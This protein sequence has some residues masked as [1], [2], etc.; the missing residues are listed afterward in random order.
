MIKGL[1]ISNIDD[2]V[3][4]GYAPKIFGQV[5]AFISA[6]FVMT[7]LRFTNGHIAVR[8]GDGNTILKQPDKILNKIGSAI[9]KRI[10]LFA[11]SFQML[12]S[13]SFDFVY[14][15][16]TPF[17]PFLIIFLLLVR[18]KHR[19]ALNIIMEIPTYPYDKQYLS[20]GVISF[21][22]LQL[23]IDFTCRHLLCYLINRF[24]VVNCTL[25]RVFGV[26]VTSINNGVNIEDFSLTGNL[27]R[28]GQP[29][30][31]VYV[32]NAGVWHGL[33]RL[34]VGLS[35]YYTNH[36]DSNKLKVRL[37]IVGGGQTNE[38]RTLSSKYGMQDYVSFVGP[39]D[40]VELDEI[41]QLAT[42]G[43]GV[44][45]SHRLSLELF[46]PLKHREY[47][48]RGLPFIYD[49]NDD[50]FLD[51]EF[52]MSVGM[53]DDPIDIDNVVSFAEKLRCESEMPQKIRAHAERDFGWSGVMSEVISSI[54]E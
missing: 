41:M 49:G 24:V 2:R 35:T 34:I 3:V 16:Y 36:N 46:S 42:V 22:A 14:I 29:V 6:G 13:D 30:C 12:K 44:L 26:P 53:C 31:L 33:D 10:Q 39:R 28:V 4:R 32:G 51:V 18:I 7:L 21:S 25:N 54:R 27:G 43:V 37:I 45:A 8:T 1:F 17:D 9:G 15:R 5:Q 23:F 50:G 40:G 47:C 52:A 38:T 48:A 19:T 20:T 11:C